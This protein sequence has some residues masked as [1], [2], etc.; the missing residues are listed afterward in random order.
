MLQGK[1]KKRKIP[2]SNEA[3]VTHG[4]PSPTHDAQASSDAQASLKMLKTS[5]TMRKASRV[6]SEHPHDARST[7]CDAQASSDMSD[8]IYVFIHQVI[9]P[10]I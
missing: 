7:K 6:T 2:Q 3:S 10:Y 8:Q 1:K 4:A 9:S 5:G